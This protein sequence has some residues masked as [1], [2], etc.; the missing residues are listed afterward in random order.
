LKFTNGS[1]CSEP[2]QPLTGNTGDAMPSHSQL[3][4][5]WCTQ[6]PGGSSRSTLHTPAVQNRAQLKQE[7]SWVLITWGK[8]PNSEHRLMWQCYMGRSTVPYWSK[9]CSHHSN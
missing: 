4:W 5:Q 9:W 2:I 6:S 1:V 7:S 8:A 3:C